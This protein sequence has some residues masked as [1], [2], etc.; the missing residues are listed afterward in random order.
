MHIMCMHVHIA[1]CHLIGSIH[2]N[3]SF[4]NGTIEVLEDIRLLPS[5]LNGS[6]V[7]VKSVY[8]ILHSPLSIT[9]RITS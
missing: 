2:N 3:Y 5:V 1:L 9:I 7:R 8:I 4:R 6:K